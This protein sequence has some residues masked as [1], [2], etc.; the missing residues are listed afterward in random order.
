MISLSLNLMNQQQVSRQSLLCR[1]VSC[2][3]WCWYISCR[4]SQ[5]SVLKWL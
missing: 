2:Q 4:P 3:N 5:W 1:W